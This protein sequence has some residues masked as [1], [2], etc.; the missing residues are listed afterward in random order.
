MDLDGV[1]KQASTTDLDKAAALLETIREENPKLWPNGLTVGH[2]SPGNLWLIQKSASDSP[3]GF[4]GWQS[5]KVEGV[6]TGYY[7]IGVLPEYRHQGI[8]KKAVA[9]LLATK[10]ASVDC[11]R[12]L[13]VSGNTFS[14]RLARS[15]DVPVEKVAGL[16]KSIAMDL[17]KGL[18]TATVTDALINHNHG[19]IGSWFPEGRAAGANPW[20]NIDFAVNILA[21]SAG[22]A[23]NRIYHGGSPS[24]L[25]RHQTTAVL[26]GMG[27][28]F[29]APAIGSTVQNA[30]T[31]KDQVQAAKDQVAATKE[32][33]GAV[34][35]GNAREQGGKSNLLPAA[36]IASALGLGAYGLYKGMGAQKSDQQAGGRL[37]VTLPTRNPTDSETTIDLP[38]DQ[39]SALSPALRQR[40]E[41]DTRRRLH[42]ETN[43]RTRRIGT[44]ALTA[45]A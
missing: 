35:K 7:S 19:A 1:V 24:T 33:V 22:R 18:G 23:S 41:R 29:V 30:F 27:K 39:F 14:E 10:A 34:G 17:L 36:L 25:A 31:F 42:A 11:V 44:Q 43:A 3:V 16:P 8:A 15:L 20:S 21:P 32:L 28:T 9:Q 37:K 2:F 6:P 40:I 4:V 45:V 12:A 5:R 26:G 13:V 38:F